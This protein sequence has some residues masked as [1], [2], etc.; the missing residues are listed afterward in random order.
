ML[1]NVAS[2][3]YKRQLR[4]L[5][6]NEVL[7]AHGTIAELISSADGVASFGVKHYLRY[8]QLSLDRADPPQKICA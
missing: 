5:A 3:S 6:A 4:E 7:S 8:A 2:A 1:Y